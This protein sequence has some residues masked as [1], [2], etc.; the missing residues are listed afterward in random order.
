MG[1]RTGLLLA[2][3]WVVAPVCAQ[4]RNAPACATAEAK[5]FDFLVG[6]WRAADNAGATM[7]SEEVLR[8]CALR[9][10]WQDARG[11]A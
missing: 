2:L 11:E 4:E 3:L 7:R 6:D 5:A 10:V 9:E 1:V 8:G